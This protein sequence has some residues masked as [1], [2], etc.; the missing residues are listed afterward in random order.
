MVQRLGVLSQLSNCPISILC[1][2]SA[3]AAQAVG[4]ARSTGS[5]IQ[6]EIAVASLASDGTHYFNKCL[7]HAA[8]HLMA[9]PLRP[10]QRAPG[11][12]AN[13]L[14]TYVNY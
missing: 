6:A 3:L 14:A 9:C 10:D 1:V 13:H 11:V 12:L 2:S 7:R 8:G 5:L 4:S